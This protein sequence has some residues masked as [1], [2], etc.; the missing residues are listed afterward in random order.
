MTSDDL[1]K[2]VKIRAFIPINQST[3]T[4]EDLLALATEEQYVGLV[5]MIL[6]MHE[7]YL[8]YTELMTVEHDKIRYTI[9]YRAIG[10]KLREV[11]FQDVSGNVYEMTRISVADLPFYNS[12]PHNRPY[13]F[14]IENNEIVLVPSQG[15]YA[16]NASLRISY[17]L[18]PN[19]LV[20]LDHVAPITAIDRNTGEIQV[21]NLPVDFNITAQLDLISNKSPNKTLKYDINANSINTTSKVIT[22]NITDIPESLSV[23]DH[24][25]LATQ[26]ALVQVPKDLHVI[27]AHRTAMRCL[28]AL[29]DQEGLAAGNQKLGEMISQAEVLIDNRVED[30]PKKAVNRHSILSASLLKRRSR[31]RGQ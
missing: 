12:Q 9:P 8:L 2:S 16:A 14:Y 29:G 4:N 24:I 1:I 21:S 19:A 10:N 22:L 27:L 6:R 31:F 30:A 5:P 25:T 11:S 18:S 15:S 28:E 3:F 26:T 13:A 7:D 17:Y 23:G 20:L